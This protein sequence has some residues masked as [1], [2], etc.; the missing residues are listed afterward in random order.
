MGDY[1]DSYQTTLFQGIHLVSQSSAMRE[2]ERS[3]LFAPNPVKFRESA[4]SA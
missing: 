3:G 1:V 2:F 4:L